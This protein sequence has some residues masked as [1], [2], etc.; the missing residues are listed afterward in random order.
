MLFA[1]LAA[2]LSI[3]G[4]DALQYA[5]SPIHAWL[6]TMLTAGMILSSIAFLCPSKRLS[7]LFLVTV[8]VGLAALAVIAMPAKDH[9]YGKGLWGVKA[10]TV[11][12]VALFPLAP[13]FS[14]ILAPD[15][16]NPTDRSSPTPVR[17]LAALSLCGLLLLGIVFGNRLIAAEDA[18]EEDRLSNLRPFVPILPTTAAACFTASVALA[19][20]ARGRIRP[21]SA[22]SLSRTILTATFALCI[23]FVMLLCVSWFIQRS[24]YLQFHLP[25]PD[26]GAIL[27]PRGWSLALATASAAG[28]ML[29]LG[30]RPRSPRWDDLPFHAVLVA[31][32]L[33]AA[34]N[35]YALR[36]TWH[37]KGS[38]YV[39]AVHAYS[40]STG[41]LLW[42][43]E[44]LSG[45][46]ETVHRENTQATPSIAV[47]DGR[48]HAFFGNAGLACLAADSGRLLWSRRDIGFDSIYGVASSP[49]VCDGRLF[50]TCDEEKTG[51]V[52]ALDSRSGATVW[53]HVRGPTQEGRSAYS[54]HSRTP[55][56]I[57][58]PN[59]TALLV[60]GWDELTAYD[61]QTGDVVQC[62][63]AKATGDHVA[64]V[65]SDS[66][67][68]FLANPDGVTAFN[69]DA[70][71]SPGA[72]Q[73]WKAKANANC[74]TP[75][76]DGERLFMV[77]DLGVVTAIDTQ[78]GTVAW[79]KR[80][81]G[82][83]RASPVIVGERLFVGDLAGRLHVGSTKGADPG[84]KAHD[85]GSPIFASVAPVTSSLLVRTEAAL[86]RLVCQKDSAAEH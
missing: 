1:I 21:A 49:V 2:A 27:Q 33:L 28:C 41:G 23:F 75:V 57:R 45:P 78:T 17:W 48:L 79:R 66:E 47:A 35:V 59:R 12:A 18:W 16:G 11:M 84:F 22:S 7:R 40:L 71:F 37:G 38:S 76:S 58:H 15:L 14:T 68:V 3:F 10:W 80:L 64:S 63:S 19:I 86:Y 69:R 25:P 83:F 8:G 26:W 65:A 61:T 55:C 42:R 53:Q 34:L 9:A 31:G 85:M 43:W 32:L 36:M 13:I 54:A 29:A 60:W 81:D 51:R 70:I 30:K 24:E 67:R 56:V 52:E 73:L 46:L 77:S 20:V 62:L 82:E 39:R 5:R 44:G 4:E 6:G 72:Q 50:I 74:S